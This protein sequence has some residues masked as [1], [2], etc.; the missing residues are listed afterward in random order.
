MFRPLITNILLLFGIAAFPADSIAQGKVAE[1]INL[2]TSSAPGALGSEPDDIP[3]LTPFFP[4]S[5]NGA[6]VIVCPGGGYTR[7]ADHEGRPVAEWLNSLGITAFVLKYRVGPRYH[8]PAPLLDAARAIRTLRAR[9]KDWNLDP[10]R[11]G[12]L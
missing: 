11:I 2:W 7:L 3:T 4:N 8:Q 9:A 10:Q 6:A 1:P 12:I 5:A